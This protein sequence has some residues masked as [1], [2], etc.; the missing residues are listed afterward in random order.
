[1]S[2]G[3]GSTRNEHLKIA[4]EDEHVTADLAEVAQHL[5]KADVPAEIAQAIRMCRL[6]AVQKTNGKVRGLNAGDSFRRL[7]ARTLAQQ[8]AEEFRAATAPFNFGMAVH[9]GAD[10]LIHLAR[11]MTDDHPDM[12]LTKIDGVGA[13]DH[14]YRASMLQKLSS[15]PTAH[16][17]LPF[18][19]MSYG[20]SSTYLWTND[21]GVTHRIPQGEGGEQGDA[22]MP[23]LFCLGLHDALHRANEQLLQGEILVAYLDDL[24]LLTSKQRARTACDVVTREIREHAGIEPNLGKTECW[25][26]G[27]GEAPER[28]EELNPP[29]GPSVWRGNLQ[30]E[31]RGVEVL[32]APLGTEEY[33][34]VKASERLAEEAKL[35]DKIPSMRNLL[36]AWLM[37]MY[38][39]AP[40]A[41]HIL[42][43]TPPSLAY[44]YADAHDDAVRRCLAALL[45]VPEPLLANNDETRRVLELPTR[46]GGLGLRSSRR[47]SPCAYWASWSDSL[48][49]LAERIPGFEAAF[50]RSMVQLAAQPAVAN[51]QRALPS[52]HEAA[53][54]LVQEGYAQVPTWHGL[55]RGLQPAQEDPAEL[56]P[57]EWRKGWQFFASNAREKREHSALMSAMPNSAR[58]RMRSCA[59][60]NAA[61]WMMAMPTEDSLRLNDATFRCAVARRLGLPIAAELET[62]DGCGRALDEYMYANRQGA[63]QAYFHRPSVETGVS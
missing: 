1:M 3:L 22:L 47:V 8:H 11:S 41:N 33:V 10:A 30:P 45:Q 48:H 5:A 24:Y 37:L 21:D 26:S 63:N 7:V 18:I 62:C 31:L 54:L 38:C 28:I 4:L 40:R 49:V 19:L 13:F 35:L 12:V 44:H 60:R 61:R 25:S 36:S 42:R 34:A 15:L 16:R 29:N 27:G 52:L 20:S 9:S 17:L 59:G 53:L 51:S 6:T 23:A 14:I 57:G 39:A 50:T 2:A 56:D 55:L 32:G 46:L 58:A 43:T